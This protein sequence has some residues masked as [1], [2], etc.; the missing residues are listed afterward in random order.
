MTLSLSQYKLL[1]SCFFP[2]SSI[3][4]C[5]QIISLLAF[6]AA[7]YFSFVVESETT[8]CSFEIQHIVVPL[9]VKTYLVVIFL[10]SLS[11]AICESTYP[12]RTV[13]EPSKHNASVEVPLKYLRIHF[14]AS[15]CSLP[16]LF[17]YMLTTPTA[18]EICGLVQIITYIKLLIVDE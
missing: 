8:F 1:F 18:C 11:P 15:Q 12:C 14:T 16:G 9:I 7:T 10:L 2:S 13:Y 17:I 6:V 3:N 4:L 5:N